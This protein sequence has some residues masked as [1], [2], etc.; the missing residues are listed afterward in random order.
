MYSCSSCRIRA[1]RLVVTTLKPETVVVVTPV[2]DVISNWVWVDLSQLNPRAVAITVTFW[3]LLR[4]KHREVHL[5]V[6][7]PAATRWATR[8]NSSL[9]L[10]RCMQI[11]ASMAV[12]KGWVNGFKPL[13]TCWE[14][15]YENDWK[16]KMFM[17]SRDVLTAVNA[18]KCVCDWLGLRVPDPVDRGYS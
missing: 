4:R 6:S 15:C 1:Y 14:F 13:P 3:V 10:L 9:H 12:F 8:A 11:I 16:W 17:L 7:V 2:T 18:S 5:S